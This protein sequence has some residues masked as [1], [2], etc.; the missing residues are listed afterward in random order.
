MRELLGIPESFDL[1]VVL[2]MSGIVLFLISVILLAVIFWRRN[3]T[4]KAHQKKLPL[5]RILWQ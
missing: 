4:N 2:A 3:I 5:N 1:I